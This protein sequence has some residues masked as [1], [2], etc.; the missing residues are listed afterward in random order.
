MHF[1]DK[2]SDLY[3]NFPRQRLHAWHYWG[4]V[5]E[6]KH[7]FPIFLPQIFGP[8]GAAWPEHFAVWLL[9]GQR[10]WEAQGRLQTVWESSQTHPVNPMDLGETFLHTQASCCRFVCQGDMGSSLWAGRRRE[11]VIM[12]GCWHPAHLKKTYL[13][14]EKR[15]LYSLGSNT[16]IFISSF[17]TW[18]KKQT[19][20]QQ[21]KAPALQNQFTCFE[22]PAAIPRHLDSQ[23]K[24]KLLLQPKV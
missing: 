21:T 22:Q 7:S 20:Q 9:C 14:W 23:Q 4:S 5:L 6:A 15:K 17:Q 1:L 19:Q 18:G 10:R 3:L 8:A 2:H 24:P 12:S 13:N 11:G 16:S